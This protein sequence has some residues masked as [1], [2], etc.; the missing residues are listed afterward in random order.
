MKR[1]FSVVL[2]SVLPVVGVAGMCPN[3][4]SLKTD[5]NSQIISDQI[6]GWTISSFDACLLPVNGHVKVHWNDVATNGKSRSAQKVHVC[7]Y[8]CWNQDL[9]SIQLKPK[10]LHTVA[11][12]G[13]KWIKF[14]HKL[15][16]GQYAPNYYCG[17]LANR[18]DAVKVTDCTWQVK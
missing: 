15:P 4:H 17:N 9:G 3:I 11:L 7:E 13:K 6:P 10:S 8:S 14:R 5:G 18:S 16:K 12:T 1:I 2:A